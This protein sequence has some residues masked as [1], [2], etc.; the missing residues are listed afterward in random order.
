MKTVS[1]LIPTYNEEDNV[2]PLYKAVKDEFRK[3]LPGYRYE[4]IFI[5]N[6]STDK[7]R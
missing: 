6:C 7:K 5:D 3:E 2:T 1:V 4:I